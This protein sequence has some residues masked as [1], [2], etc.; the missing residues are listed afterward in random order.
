[1]PL[2][3]NLCGEFGGKY[4]T[5]GE[6]GDAGVVYHYAIAVTAVTLSALVQDAY[7]DKS[8]PAA[9]AAAQSAY[10]PAGSIIYGQISS[11]TVSTGLLQL[12]E[13]DNLGVQ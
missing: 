13:W 9:L 5:D 10:Y 11:I 1:M 4:I 12:V 2:I 3:K 7:T 6:S 8:S